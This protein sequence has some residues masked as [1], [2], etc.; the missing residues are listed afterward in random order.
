MQPIRIIIVDDHEIMREGLVQLLQLEEGIEIVATAS[1][2]RQAIDLIKQHKPDIVLLDVSMD[3]I[4]GLEV[5]KIIKPELPETK[6]I[7]VTMHEEK[8]FFLQALR[9]GAT[10]Y[11]LKGSDS[12]E[13]I[14]TIYKVHAGEVYLSPKMAGGLIQELLNYEKILNIS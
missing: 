6:I 2:G 4:S 9:A 3:D 7:I 10:G 5:T 12:E 1:N 8:A 11:F 14:Q 13:L